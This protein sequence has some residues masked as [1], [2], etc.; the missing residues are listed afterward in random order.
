MLHSLEGLTCHHSPFP[1][2]V[3]ATFAQ[4]VKIAAQSACRLLALWSP[5]AFGS[6]DLVLNKHSVVSFAGMAPQYW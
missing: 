4:H 2:G 5:S 3:D 1:A 6:A